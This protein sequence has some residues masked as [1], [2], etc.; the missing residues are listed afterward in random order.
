MSCK[1]ASTLLAIACIT[2]LQAEESK[3]LWELG[4]GLVGLNFPDY[5]GSKHQRNYLLPL[6]YLIYRGER[7]KVN[8]EG[9]RGLLYDSEHIKLDIS[10]DGG[11][12]VESDDNTVRGGMPDLDP[13]FEIGPSL[14]ILLAKNAT[15]K[16]SLRLP[17]RAAFATDFT[18]ID[19]EGWLFHPQ[20]GLDAFVDTTRHWKFG[21]A[22]GPLYASRD[23]HD[24][25]YGVAHAYAAKGG[26]S[27]T[28][29]AMSLSW[30]RD[31]LQ[32]GAFLRY[33]DLHGTAFEDSPLLEQ[34]HSFMAG[35]AIG[36]VL[37]RSQRRVSVADDE[38]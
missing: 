28:R 31:R 2:T 11:V 38:Q 32:F 6:P 3:P 24:Y 33:D 20:L 17:V 7:L 30:Q 36:W 19:H 4:V 25:Y 16:L 23:Y 13:M 22:V 14:K 10:L 37:V 35:F 21:I 26:Y 5:R 8:R 15:S 27:G 18:Y 34:D 12:P 29:L 9:L 1:L